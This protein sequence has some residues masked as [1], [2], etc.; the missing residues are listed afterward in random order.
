MRVYASNKHV[1]ELIMW[2]IYATSQA[3]TAIRSEANH[4]SIMINDY[5][6]KQSGD[7]KDNIFV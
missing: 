2:V 7:W 6:I 3:A 5:V 1:G 4:M